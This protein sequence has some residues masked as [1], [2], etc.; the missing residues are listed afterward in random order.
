MHMH[1]MP[2]AQDRY[3]QIAAVIINNVNLF[4]NDYSRWCK[5]DFATYTFFIHKKLDFFKNVK[6]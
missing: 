6:M 2:E 1:N 4:T 5:S 3:R